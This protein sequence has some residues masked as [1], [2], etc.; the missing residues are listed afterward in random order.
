MRKHFQEGR[1]TPEQS[2]VRTSGYQ[3]TTIKP[4]HLIASPGERGAMSH[5]DD[6]RACATLI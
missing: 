6:C 4:K 1:K 5:G 3:L 2:L